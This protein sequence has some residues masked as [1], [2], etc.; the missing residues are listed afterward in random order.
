M[1]DLHPDAKLGIG[2]P[3]VDGFY[4]D[5]DVAEP[6]TPD[7]LGE[8]EKQMQRIVKERQRF[9]RRVVSDDEARDRAGARAVQARADRRQGLRDGPTTGRAPRSAPAS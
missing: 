2:P 9:R 1:Q 3:I 8:L 4:Y 7:D 5:F 6:F